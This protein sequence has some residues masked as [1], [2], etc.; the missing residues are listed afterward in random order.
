MQA[1]RLNLCRFFCALLLVS[2]QVAVAQNPSD[3]LPGNRDG[4]LRR[5]DSLFAAGDYNL[6]EQ[7]F[8][9]H[10][11]TGTPLTDAALLKLAFIYEKQSNVPRMLYFLQRYFDRNPNEAILKKMNEVAEQQHLYG[12]ETDDLNYFYLFYR[13]FGLY[14][15]VGLLLLAAYVFSVFWMKNRRG[16][17]IR[18]KHKWVVMLYL[19]GLLLLVNLPER[20]KAGIIN[21]ESVYLRRAPSAAAPVATIVGKG[22]KVSI[23]GSEDIWLRVYWHDGLYYVRRDNVWEI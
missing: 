9:A 2:W 21:R 18:Q 6:A 14:L 1:C 12:Y 4:L 16:E 20:Y 23:L 5:A 15:I 22:H 3:R 10:L 11:A 19:L 13:Q 7:Q 8:R 17:P